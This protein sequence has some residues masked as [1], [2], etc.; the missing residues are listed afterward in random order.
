MSMQRTFTFAVTTLLLSTFSANPFACEGG[1]DYPMMAQH[2]QPQPSIPPA[3][4]KNFAPYAFL[5]FSDEQHKQIAELMF[6]T[7]QKN[8]ERARKIGEHM[9]KFQQLSHQ[10][11]IDM[12][13]LRMEAEAIAELRVEQMLSRATYMEAFHAIMTPE[14]K[15]EMAKKH[16][17]PEAEAEPMTAE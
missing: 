6:T 2:H 16:H 14:Q 12:E 8:S 17:H 1:A 4:M 5:N 15:A 13:A 9:Q 3:M 10:H 11:G 7:G